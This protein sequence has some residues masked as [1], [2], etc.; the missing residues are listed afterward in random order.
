VLAKVASEDVESPRRA[1]HDTV[2]LEVRLQPAPVRHHDD[3]VGPSVVNGLPKG[4]QVAAGSAPPRVVSSGK[5][6]EELIARSD[7]IGVAEGEFVVLLRLE[8]V[9]DPA[10][11][12]VLA[13]QDACCATAAG[14][15]RAV[16][17]DGA[18]VGEQGTCLSHVHRWHENPA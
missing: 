12:A 5:V 11:V 17:D 10:V 3:Q 18:G 9:E 1:E 14:T 6:Q 16:H 4:G 15:R 8:F 2:V 13:Q 7:E